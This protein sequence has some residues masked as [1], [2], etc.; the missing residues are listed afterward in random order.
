MMRA[1]VLAGRSTAAVEVCAR[2]DPPPGH[3]RVRLEGSA[4]CASNLPVWQGRP[5]F[6][7]PLAPGAPGHEGWGVVD[8]A[9]DDVTTLD[10]G[11]R[12]AFLSARAFAEWD[13]ADARQALKLP[14]TVDQTP[15]PGEPLACAINVVRRARI[16]PG[17]VVVV[18]GIGFLGAVVTRVAAHRGATVLA[19]SRRAFARDLAV[20][21]G[22]ELALPFDQ[23]T[24][25]AAVADYTGGQLAPCVIEATGEQSALDL[26]SGLVGVRGRLVIAGYHQDGLRQVDMQRWNWQ[27]I[28]VINAHERN[29]DVYMTGMREAVEL[30]AH[31]VIDANR[32]ITHWIPLDDL[33]RGFDL[34]QRRPDGFLKAAIRFE[35]RP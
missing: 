11:D 6:T 13:I 27:G 30:L 10:E 31:G 23:P 22:A 9:G 18:V 20:E 14:A 33:D 8:R 4:I 19:V 25:A 29:P 28:D 17:E 2:P 5:W 12:V 35:G 32:L 16:Q 3:V 21:L 26:A 24:V 15:C 34:L 7:Y 1:A